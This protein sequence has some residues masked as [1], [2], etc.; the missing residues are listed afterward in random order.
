M[1]TILTKGEKVKSL[2]LLKDWTVKQTQSEIIVKQLFE[3]WKKLSNEQLLSTAFQEF[4][5]KACFNGLS[6]TK[7]ATHVKAMESHCW[8]QKTPQQKSLA[9]ELKKINEKLNY[10]VTKITQDIETLRNGENIVSFRKVGEKN[11]RNNINLITPESTNSSNKQTTQKMQ[12]K[13]RKTS[14]TPIKLTINCEPQQ[15]D[16]SPSS[17]ISEFS[18]NL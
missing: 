15:I 4:V 3:T 10:C 18:S 9:L 11:K 17:G 14:V 7:R 8:R 16:V 5:F 6:E 1:T 2:E 13:N 12:T